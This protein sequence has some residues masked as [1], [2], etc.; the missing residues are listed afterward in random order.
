[1]LIVYSL[2]FNCKHESCANPTPHC[3]Q[4]CLCFVDTDVSTSSISIFIM[5]N[6]ILC[7]YCSFALVFVGI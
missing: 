5:S 7:T 3:L 4:R 2:V 1:M 6:H